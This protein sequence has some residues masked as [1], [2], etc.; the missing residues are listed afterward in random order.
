MGYF[1]GDSLPKILLC[2]IT[3]SVPCLLGYGLVVWQYPSLPCKIENKSTVYVMGLVFYMYA[4]VYKARPC[5][6]WSLQ[7]RKTQPKVTMLR[8]H[9]IYPHGH[10]FG[11][12]DEQCTHL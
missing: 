7:L 5:S 1:L 6:T 4:E 8:H 2:Q 10:P 11:K 3:G 12:E 9:K